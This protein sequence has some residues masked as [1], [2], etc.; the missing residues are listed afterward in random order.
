MH[1]LEQGGFMMWP[2]LAFSILSLG[3]IGE[4]F[5]AYTTRRFPSPDKLAPAFAAYRNNDPRSAIRLIEDVAP[6]YVPLFAAL[7]SSRP[8]ALKEKDVRLAGEALL[9]ALNRRL[10]LLATTASAA[11]LMGLLGTVVGMIS[12]FSTLSSSGNVDITLLAGGIWQALLTTAAGLAVA[13]PA[14]LAH[15]WFCNQYDKAAHAMQH[16]ANGFMDPPEGASA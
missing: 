12:T 2:I 1:I 8:P 11:P 9:F 5:I 16:A 4:R 7:F 15:R 10:E 13:I 14:L 6:F 3:V